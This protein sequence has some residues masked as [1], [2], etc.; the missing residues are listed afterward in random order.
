MTYNLREEMMKKF[1]DS[2]V[3]GM[4]KQAQVKQPKKEVYTY[5]DENDQPY[6][7]S[8]TVDSWP[9]E[10]DTNTGAGMQVEIEAIVPDLPEN[11]T[12]EQV[13]EEI[14]QHVK[15]TAKDEPQPEPDWDA[16]RE[17]N[18]IKKMYPDY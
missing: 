14:E 18:V 1:A 7:V 5:Y 4:T 6:T 17:E 15:D 16:V 11:I 13:A 9:A 3:K 8:Y 2:L 12:E 10:L